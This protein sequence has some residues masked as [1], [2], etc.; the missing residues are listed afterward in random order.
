LVGVF[1]V[2]A[3]VVVATQRALQRGVQRRALAELALDYPVLDA[4]ERE[5]DDGETLRR[6]GAELARVC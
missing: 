4:C 3:W 5:E 2:V 6:L 1:F